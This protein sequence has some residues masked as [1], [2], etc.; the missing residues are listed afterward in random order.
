MT[1][2]RSSDAAEERFLGECLE[3]LKEALARQGLEEAR[4]EAR[5]K[6]RAAADAKR[7]RRPSERINDL[8]GIRIVVDHVGL[9]D[10]VTEVIKGWEG[11]AGLRLVK[12]DDYFVHPGAG[13]YRAR[14]FDFEIIDPLKVGL[15][16]EAGVEVQVTTAILAAIS[17]VSHRLLYGPGTPA[18]F[19][20]SG[21]L[22]KLE[23]EALRLDEWLAAI[24]SA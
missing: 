11:P 15:T 2:A 17:C 12:T 13:G 24:D 5:V 10:D 18:G 4:L 8:V 22:A 20:I 19:A 23:A 6:T 1:A 21:E 14:H 16:P 3:Q 9:L 7:L